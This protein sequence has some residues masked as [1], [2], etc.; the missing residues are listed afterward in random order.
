MDSIQGAHKESFLSYIPQD[1]KGERVPPARV[2]KRE[3]LQYASK[4]IKLAHFTPAYLA[5]EN[6]KI[7]RFDSR[8]NHKLK[9]AK[10]VCTYRFYQEMNDTAINAERPHNEREI[11]FNN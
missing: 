8:L 2:R 5:E 9:V 7:N 6:L 1:R 10:L 11:F 3:H 4:F